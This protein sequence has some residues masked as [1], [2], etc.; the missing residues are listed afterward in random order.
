MTTAWSGP[1]GD[2]SID[3]NP[4][5][6]CLPPEMT[7]AEIADWLNQAPPQTVLLTKSRVLPWLQSAFVA[8]KLSVMIASSVLELMR[9]AAD[10]QDPRVPA[11]RA[12]ALQV[13]KALA[14]PATMR[15]NASGI[16]VYGITGVGKSHIF[17]LLLRRIPQVVD[18]GPNF[19]C[20]MLG[21][22]QLV[23]LTIY[24]TGDGTPKAFFIA[25]ILQID[26]IL[27]TN[28]CSEVGDRDSVATM[29]ALFMHKLVLHRVLFLVIEECQERNIAISKH[30]GIFES[31]F[32]GLLNFGIPT[33]LVGN[34]QGVQPI[35]KWSQ[36][37]RRLSAGGKFRLDPALDWRSALWMRDYV[38]GIWTCKPMQL[39]DEL[40][41]APEDIP[42]ML[43][44]LT[45]G[46]P[47]FLVKLRSLS[48]KSAMDRGSLRV[49]K[50][51]IDRAYASPFYEG[52]LKLIRAFVERDA[53]A[54]SSFDDVDVEHYAQLWTRDDRARLIETSESATP[55]LSPAPT[56][57]VASTPPPVASQPTEA[58]HPS[59]QESATRAEM[60][61]RRPR[62]AARSGARN[63]KQFPAE[64]VR[65]AEWL[66][67]QPREIDL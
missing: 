16:L 42:R 24:L 39:P 48:I 37:M 38:P 3:G 61:R 56:D 25:A 60:T 59:V 22:R 27:G 46:F 29:M 12:R 51:D 26:L 30:S 35:F 21:L 34:P 41:C 57:S 28:Y 1:W 36:I 4:L 47:D 66:L 19:A 50:S 13:G 7:Y 15:P 17:S 58:G 8:T 53:S 10:F 14:N 54:L 63:A 44:F 52:N 31:L 65:S 67:S 40:W 9:Q 20:A 33:A 18:H 55:E 64:D 6:R 5:L 43:W 23:H 49:E 32:L 2:D 45:G 11:N 62:K